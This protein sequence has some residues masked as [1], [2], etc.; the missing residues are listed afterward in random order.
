[1][2]ILLV[3]AVHCLAVTGE[4]DFARQGV[5]AGDRLVRRRAWSSVLLV[6]AFA[7]PRRTTGAP[8]LVV[9]GLVGGRS[10]AGR[11]RLHGLR[12]VLRTTSVRALVGFAL[13]A[14]V[15]ILRWRQSRPWLL[16]PAVDAGASVRRGGCQRRARV[17]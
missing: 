3:G 4:R 7:F 1:M 14:L 17:A 2:G 6:R 12:S 8:A 16:G 11:R 13:I 15:G 10:R 9:G 5:G